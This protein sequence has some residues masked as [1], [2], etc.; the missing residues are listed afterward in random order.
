M[1]SEDRARALVE[2]AEKKLSSW[3]LFSS[4]SK[5]ED[6]SEMYVKA[7]N[8][9]KVAKCWNDAG[10]CFE[11]AAG[12]H[13]K[14]D[15]PHEAATA[16]TEAANCYK[17]TDAKMA[18]LQYKEAV[19][20]QI[21]LGRFQSAAKLQKEI[22]ELHE[23]EGNL[24]KVHRS[25]TPNTRSH[26]AIANGHVAVPC[27]YMVHAIK[28]PQAQMDCTGYPCVHELAPQQLASC[29]TAIFEPSCLWL[30]RQWRPFRQRQTTTRARS[31]RLRPT[32]ACSRWQTLPQRPATSKRRS[33]STN[34]WRSAA[35]RT[36]C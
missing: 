13:L 36:T 32:S 6:A 1:S 5:F 35:W 21:D 24:L 10:M 9:F 23:A 14:C 11:K 31:P 16:Y 3:S 4:G 33:K 15:S 19:G 30:R 2:K 7:A 34:R 26:V 22:A 29:C 20:I 27:C 18:V 28:D 17:K 8:L 12:C 25:A